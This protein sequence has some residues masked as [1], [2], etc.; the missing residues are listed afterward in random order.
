M[1]EALKEIMKRRIISEIAHQQTIEG[2]PVLIDMY[3]E[4]MAEAIVSTLVDDVSSSDPILNPTVGEDKH[5]EHSQT[6]PSDIW[7]IAHNLGKYPSVTVTDSAGNL[8]VGGVEFIDT[9]L[10]RIYFSSPFSG[11]AYLN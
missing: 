11:K 3:A 1:S 7:T 2:G 9:S 6:S 10:L 5:F 4:A 8:V